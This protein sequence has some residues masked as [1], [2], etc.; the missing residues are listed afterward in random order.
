MNKML[1]M[2]VRNKIVL[3]VVLALS[4]FN[5]VGYLMKNNLGAIVLFLMV[6]FGMTH[7]TKNMVYVL[8]T[9][10]VATNFL[11]MSGVLSSLGLRE[12]LKNNDD[13]SDTD[14]DDAHEDD[15]DDHGMDNHM[16][17]HMADDDVHSDDAHDND[18][19]YYGND[20]LHSHNSK[21]SGLKHTNLKLA[22]DKKH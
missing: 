18:E 19:M 11:V 14:T 6:G 12:G 2:L 10:I 20:S 3:Y 17:N 1:N 21:S 16:D 4:V 15:S 7:V 8:L 9:A 22:N 13:E 5:L